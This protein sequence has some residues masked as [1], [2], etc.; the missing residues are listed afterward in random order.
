M[1][2]ANWTTRLTDADG[3]IDVDG[4]LDRKLRLMVIL[5]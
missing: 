5:I 3:E 2:D 4:L 1:V